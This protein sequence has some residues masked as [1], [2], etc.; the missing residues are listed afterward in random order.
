[1]NNKSTNSQPG[2]DIGALVRRY[3]SGDLDAFGEL[4]AANAN[5]LYTRLRRMGLDAHEAEDVLQDTFIEATAHLSKL[6]SDSSVISWLLTIAQ[7]L[8]WSRRRRQQRAI[9]APSG[10]ATDIADNLATLAGKQTFDQVLDLMA[11][12]DLLNKLPAEM[13]EIATLR[14]DGYTTR[15]IASNMGVSRRTVTESLHRLRAKVQQG[16]EPDE[17]DYTSTARIRSE[18][19]AQST[20]AQAIQTLPVRRR[21]VLVRQVERGLRPKE[22]AAELNISP[23][24]ARVHL[25]LAYTELAERLGI[26]REALIKQLKPAK[27]SAKS[28]PRRTVA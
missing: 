14:G 15:E 7:R 2:S 3:R 27:L 8:A 22:I 9:E 5:R 12:D 6:Q 19:A 20:I 28:P 26:P 11:I 10:S 16:M 25:N 23:N 24:C 13:R 17:P 1:M 18:T 21:E 4:Y